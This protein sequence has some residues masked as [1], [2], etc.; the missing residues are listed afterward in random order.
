M[1]I[2]DVTVNNVAAMN[3]FNWLLLLL[4][5]VVLATSVVAELRDIK[6]CLL[7]LDRADPPVPAGWRVALRGL[8]IARRYTFLPT[9][10][11]MQE[12]ASAI[13]IG[14]KA[15]RLARAGV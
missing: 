2:E 15:C 12:I 8:A 1:I 4:A 5:S 9:L 14:A 11:K 13:Q 6:L 3:P 10:A 7:A